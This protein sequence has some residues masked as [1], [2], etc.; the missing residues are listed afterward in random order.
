MLQNYTYQVL[1]YTDTG[2]CVAYSYGHNS[3]GLKQMSLDT[4]VL[5]MDTF[6][7]YAVPYEFSMIAK[8]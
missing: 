1:S 5:C 7:H 6:H 2:H 3:S 4:L 8:T